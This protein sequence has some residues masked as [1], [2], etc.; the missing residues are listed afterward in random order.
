[1]RP[2]SQAREDF[3]REDSPMA[4]VSRMQLGR[5]SRRGPLLEN[6]G[7]PPEPPDEELP[8]SQFSQVHGVF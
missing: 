5:V 2:G 8:G 7:S 1:M 4:A 3:T 6:S